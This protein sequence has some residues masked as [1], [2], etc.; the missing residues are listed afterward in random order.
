MY[1]IQAVSLGF[2]S[3]SILKNRE[4]KI[5]PIAFVTG[6]GKTRQL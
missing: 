6:F 1:A 2:F 3:Y 4:L 5:L